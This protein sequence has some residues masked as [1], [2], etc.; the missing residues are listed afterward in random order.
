MEIG[1][2]EISFKGLLKSMAL[3]NMLDHVPESPKYIF[4]SQL[5]KDSQNLADI[6][7]KWIDP[8]SKK[9]FKGGMSSFILWLF[10]LLLTLIV[11]NDVDVV[12]HKLILTIDRPALAVFL[13]S[14]IEA[15]NRIFTDL[16]AIIGIFCE[17]ISFC[18]FSLFLKSFRF[19]FQGNSTYVPSIRHWQIL[20]RQST[21]FRS[22]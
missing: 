15:L 12:V 3:I 14:A 1:N 10:L 20:S 6:S 5:E 9:L 4:V 13:N 7:Y 11:E 2:K 16:K 22:H 17:F 8:T 21:L 19:R 18:Q